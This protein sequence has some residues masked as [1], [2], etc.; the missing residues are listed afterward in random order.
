MQTGFVDWCDACSWNLSAPEEPEATGRLERLYERV[1]ARMGDRL[2][3]ELLAA[4]SLE[5]HLTPAN[6][7]AYAIAA[8]V[9]VLPLVFVVVGVALPVLAF[10]N[11]FAFVAAAILLGLAW[12]M[13][14]RFGEQPDEGI[15]SRAEAPEL[16]RV[17]DDV[18]AA[19]GTRTIDTLV[20][21]HRFNANWNVV[22]LRRRRVLTLGLPLFEALAPEPR[23]ALIG[24]ELGHG[25][26]GDVRRGLFVG[27]A[28][29]SLAEIYNVLAP[30]DVMPDFM[31]GLGGFERVINVFFRI[32]SRP[33]W[34]LLQLELHLLLRDDQRAEYYA[35]ALAADVAGTDATVAL[36][37]TLLLASTVDAAVQRTA[38]AGRDAD[39]FADLHAALD[40]VPERER[41]RRRR[42][43]R[44][45]PARLNATHPPTAKRLELLEGRRHREPKVV[46]DGE[47]A[48][49]VDAEL[50]RHHRRI[51]AWLVDDH[52]DRLYY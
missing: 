6:A 16:H 48:A 40:A 15:V 26:N 33:F 18:A 4:D 47:R 29:N 20:V 41:E 9:H 27:T 25:R 7:T 37:E 34:W 50:A 1:G 13:R 31:G 32:L 49:A 28:V 17:I 52:R 2:S 14:P 12:L 30:Y 8:V 24:H 10:P 3:R 44:L 39:L 38:H 23:V 43:A 11:P 46:L 35:D 5:P 21:D 42:V 45:M 36:K 22:G 19:L 51:Q